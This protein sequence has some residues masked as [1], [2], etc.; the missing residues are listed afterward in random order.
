MRHERDLVRGRRSPACTRSSGT[1]V[2]RKAVSTQPTV[3]L[4]HGLGG[5]TVNWELVGAGLASRLA[6]R[7]V[8]FDLAGFGRTPLGSRRASLGANGRLLADSSPTSGPSSIDGQLDGWRDRRRARGPPPRARPRARARR[9]GAPARAAATRGSRI[10][11]RARQPRWA[12]G[13]GDA[14]RSVRGSSATACGRLGPGGTVDA[15]PA[16]RVRAPGR[17]STRRCASA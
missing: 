15:T 8:A 1:A 11:R 4:V 14:G 13:G 12:R 9:P 3:V 7:V 16:H 6:T 5:S 2:R 10:A 17:G